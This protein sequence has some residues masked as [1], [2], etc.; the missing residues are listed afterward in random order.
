MKTLAALVSKDLKRRLRSPVHLLLTLAFPFVLLG[1]IGLAFYPRGGKTL[2]A[3]PIL[4]ENR[5]GEFLGNFLGSALRNER[6]A[7]HFD[8]ELV[9]PGTGEKRIAEGD[10]AALLVVP[11]G[12]TDSVLDGRPTSLLLVKNPGGVILPEIAQSGAELLAL[13]L[14]AA[15]RTLREPLASIR[16]MIEGTGSPADGAVAET[17]VLA[18]GA[19]DRAG[20][21]VLPP[22]IRVEEVLEADGDE[23]GAGAFNIF[24]Y[25]FPGM[26]VLGLLF[27][28]QI[29]MRDL[30]RE[31]R[32]GQLARLLSSPVPMRTVVLSKLVSTLF[33]L[34][35]CHFLFAGAAAVVFRVPI[36]DI[37]ASV[38]LVLAQGLAVT[39]ILA[40]LFALA[41]TERQGEAI[42]SVVI[43]SMSLL[44]GSMFP[45]D[46]F[47][48][49]MRGLGRATP[50]YWAIEGFRAVLLE[51]AG[52]ADV[53]PNVLV[54]ALIGAA[55]S[56]LA[57]FTLGRTLGEKG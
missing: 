51:G 52:A 7:E 54:L 37:P 5:D 30:M 31:R 6:M 36:G 19:I 15:A 35:I 56:A 25:L 18:K 26:V 28:A 43:L 47:P 4:L 1:I 50:N 53:A 13:V 49:S 11:D 41:R 23:E 45:T 10:A 46:L 17:A 55:T 44:G 38:L 16:S 22:A 20:R 2:P 34:V 57:A 39:G 48:E 42:S 40:L 14:S 29:S 9:E 3:V 27:I 32:A 33:L 24:A 21:F 12:F 8:V